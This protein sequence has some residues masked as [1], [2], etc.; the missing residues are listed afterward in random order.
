MCAKC[1]Y[2]NRPLADGAPRTALV[3]SDSISVGAGDGIP[4]YFQGARVIERPHWATAA[5]T[6]RCGT[7][8][9]WV[10]EPVTEQIRAGRHDIK[11]VSA[12]TGNG[13]VV[14]YGPQ[15]GWRN[16]W[17]QPEAPGVH[18]Y[19]ARDTGQYQF[20]SQNLPQFFTIPD[21]P[22]KTYAIAAAAANGKL[23]SELDWSRRYTA[24]PGQ[25]LVAVQQTA[26]RRSR[27]FPGYTF[28][29]VEVVGT[30]TTQ[31]ETKTVINKSWEK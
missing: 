30:I 6:S 31:T 7:E 29:V 3:R 17:V 19:K 28:A 11:A 26:E 27:R 21:L 8:V 9:Y 14:I 2:N 25:S 10:S 15:A 20:E 24:Y 13:R 22:K 1:R 4:Q 16:V 23:L 18:L 12:T 5:I